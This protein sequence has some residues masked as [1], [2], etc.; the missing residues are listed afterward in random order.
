MSSEGRGRHKVKL[1]QRQSRQITRPEH[2]SFTG[3]HSH[4][5]FGAAGYFS[6]TINNQK[7]TLSGWDSNPR[8]AAHLCTGAG[9]GESLLLGGGRGDQ[10]AEETCG[11][12]GPQVCVVLRLHTQKCMAHGTPRRY[13]DHS[14]A[15]TSPPADAEFVEV[16]SLVFPRWW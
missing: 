12:C 5:H 15:R 16:V 3:E 2:R 8:P 11:T 4:D 13:R 10:E 7:A 6:L 9:M 1:T 14:G